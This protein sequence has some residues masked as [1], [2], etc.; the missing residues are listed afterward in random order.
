MLALANTIK[1]PNNALLPVSNTVAL[2]IVL[3]IMPS[4]TIK[5]AMKCF[6]G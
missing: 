2:I 1:I 5:Q 6:Y 3:Y 4:A